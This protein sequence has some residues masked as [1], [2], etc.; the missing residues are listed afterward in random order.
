MMRNWSGLAV[1]LAL[2]TT[3]AFAECNGVPSPCTI[4][5]GT[6]HIVVPN[7]VKGPI[8]AV[9]FLHGYGGD[10]DGTIRNKT[11]VN[12]L[13]QRGYAVIAPDGQLRKSGRGRSWDFHPDRPA[14]RDETAFLNAVA[15][16]ASE[17]FG[18]ARDGMLLAGFSIGG[19]LTSYVA[20]NAPQSFSA[21]APVAGSFWR[22]HPEHCA[23]PV[24]VL[25]THGTADRT[26]PMTGREIYPGFVQGNVYEAMD[27]WRATDG[28]KATSPDAEEHLG[29][30]TIQH[31]TSCA[32]GAR[33]D[34]ALHDGGHGVPK[35]WV[36]MVM[37]WFEER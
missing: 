4:D 18:L 6:Y 1:A 34:F 37:N 23:A 19:S 10:G 25:H 28:C 8:P 3:A 16:D 36:E 7:D 33:L 5:T 22:P 13:L 21:Y 11:M 20:C 30:F 29:I 17:K 24:R 26:V 12:Y 27:I 35:G 9:M 31:W 15:D 14:S 32:P 2:C